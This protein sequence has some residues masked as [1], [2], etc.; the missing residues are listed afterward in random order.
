MAPGG[1]PCIEFTCL[2]DLAGG[3]PLHAWRL[4]SR[5]CTKQQRAVSRIPHGCLDPHSLGGWWPT[6]GASAYQRPSSP[7]EPQWHR[8]SG[9]RATTMQ[10]A[11]A[12]ESARGAAGLR[13]QGPGHASVVLLMLRNTASWVSTV[14]VCSPILATRQPASRNRPAVNIRMYGHM[15]GTSVPLSGPPR[16]PEEERGGAA[17]VTQCCEQCASAGQAVQQ[18]GSF[19]GVLQPL[20]GLL[21]KLFVP[22]SRGGHLSP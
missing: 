8:G 19:C 11:S 6:G 16:A 3:T 20:S 13:T 21:W 18:L 9:W 12:A 1:K 17:A 2:R 15:Q 7:P 22:H 4:T 10:K 5:A 14:T